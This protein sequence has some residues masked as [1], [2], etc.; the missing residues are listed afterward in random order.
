MLVVQLLRRAVTV[1]LVAPVAPRELRD[2]LQTVP[3]QQVE[4]VLPEVLVVQFQLE[5]WWEETV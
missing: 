1:E 5:D 4:R 2:L 3:R